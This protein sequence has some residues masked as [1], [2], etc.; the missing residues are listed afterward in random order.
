[1]TISGS[2]QAEIVRLYHAEHWRVGT[3][4][5]QLGVHYSTV[6]RVLLREG[7]VLPT[8][9]PRRSMLDPYVPFIVETLDKYPRLSAARV[10]EMLTSR[11]YTGSPDHLRHRLVRYRPRRVAE[12]Y[13][14]LRTLP[15]EQVQIDWAHFGKLTIGRAQ[16][17][18]MAFVMVLSYSR[19]VFVRFYLSA[20]MA[21]FLRG[22][23]EAFEF[24]GA[25]PRVALY[26]NLKAPCLNGAVTPSVLTP[27]CSSSPLTIASPH[28]QSHRIVAM[29]KAV[30]NA[31]FAL[32]ANASSPHASS[33]I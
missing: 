23:V 30:S 5:T 22:H 24:F 16:R 31:P 28:A 19:H 32:C 17:P 3:I 27:H 13:L 29:K 4:A 6:R 18:L 33:A 1:M 14:R 25:V 8:S 26:D 2:V 20:A 12:A 9:S 21:S 15:G 7:L 11:G 10:Y